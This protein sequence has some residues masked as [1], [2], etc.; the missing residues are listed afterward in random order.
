MVLQV[1]LWEAAA[2]RK[3]EKVEKEV[4]VSLSITTH[5]V[6]SSFLIS[7]TVV[8]MSVLKLASSLKFRK[9][10]LSDSK[11]GTISRVESIPARAKA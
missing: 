3:E 6:T 5:P 9:H 1:C 10:L 7:D 8:L 2:V 4:V 11:T